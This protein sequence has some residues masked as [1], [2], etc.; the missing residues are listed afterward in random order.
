MERAEMK[1]RYPGESAEYREARDRLLTAEV[2]LRRQ[3]EA[4]AAARRDLPPS[5]E[6]PEDY[7][8]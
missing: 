5:G 7:V 1:V 4:V 3:I 2:E 6:V 8:G